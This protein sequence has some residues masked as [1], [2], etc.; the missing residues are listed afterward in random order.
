[1]RTLNRILGATVCLL[2]L[3]AS[4]YCIH[5]D[6]KDKEVAVLQEMRPNART[7]DTRFQQSIRPGAKA[8]CDSKNL[9]CNPEGKINAFVG[10]L[11]T[12]EDDATPLTCGPVG[13]AISKRTVKVTGG[14]TVRVVDNRRYNPAKKESGLSPYIARVWTH[15]NKDVTGP[16][17]LPCR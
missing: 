1:M 8:C 16:N 13:M 10:L 7:G 15:D 4:A 6:T 9:E 17:G 12:V 2:A 5:N 3:P 11:V 14:G